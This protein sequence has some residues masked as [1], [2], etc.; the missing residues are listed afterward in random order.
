MINV[1][2]QKPFQDPACHKTALI[3]DTLRVA[4]CD[5]DGVTVNNLYRS[6]RQERS[7]I[8]PGHSMYHACC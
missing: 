8:G 7:S 5:F 3:Y 6:V 2:R 4:Q 1:F